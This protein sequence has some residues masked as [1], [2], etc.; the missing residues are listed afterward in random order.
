MMK[1]H[2][3]WDLGNRQKCQ[4]HG[5]SIL[6]I[7]EL[8]RGPVTVFDDPS[9]SLSEQRL[10]GIGKMADKRGILVVFTFR[11]QEEQQIIR[12]I[13]ARYMHQEEIDFYEKQKP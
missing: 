4:K 2:F 5:V 13:S 6:E 10:K 1:A 3:D 11:N 8:F 9:H 7:E 12:P